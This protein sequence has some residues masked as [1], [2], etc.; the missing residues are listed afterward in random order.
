MRREILLLAVITACA[1]TVP[2][3]RVLAWG[4]AG[5]PSY[6]LARAA[7]QN[8]AIANLQKLLAVDAV[9]FIY[10]ARSDDTSVELAS[11]NEKASY[12][13]TEFVPLDKGWAS[14]AAGIRPQ[15]VADAMDGE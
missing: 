9:T 7:A 14:K 6:F 1:P 11:A 12:E 10:R 5:G 3:N 4:M 8:R 2:K 13:S 15:P